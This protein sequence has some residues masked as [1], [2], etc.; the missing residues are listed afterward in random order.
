MWY[1]CEDCSEKFDNAVIKLHCRKH[2][3][4]FDTNSGKFVTTFCYK[5]R[6]SDVFSSSMR[7]YCPKCR[8]MN[9]DKLN[10]F[11]HKKCGYIAESTNFDFTNSSQSVCPSCKKEIK[12][13]DKEI[14]VPAM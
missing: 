9:V 8:S 2:D 5:L 12:N 7:L 11:E 4:D 1:Q 13:F 6:N 10:L 14:R 3:H